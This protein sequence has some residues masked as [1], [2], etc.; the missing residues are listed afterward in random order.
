[1]QK[2]SN[3]EAQIKALPAS[4]PCYLEDRNLGEFALTASLVRRD[5]K[6]KAYIADPKK[7]ELAAHCISVPD[8]LTYTQTP[9]THE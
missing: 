8:N 4:G 6:I 3:F 5:L 9:E 2:N 1:M 7:R